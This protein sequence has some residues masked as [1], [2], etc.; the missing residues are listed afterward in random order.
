MTDLS[1]REYQSF[2]TIS[3]APISR[4]IK[5]G[6]CEVVS[7][8]AKKSNPEGQPLIS[9][10]FSKLTIRSVAEESEAFL[11]SPE[12]RVCQ[13]FRSFGPVWSADVTDA[14]KGTHLEAGSSETNFLTM[15][16]ICAPSSRCTSS[17]C[18]IL[19]GL[20]AMMLTSITR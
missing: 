5:A 10:S 6:C 16:S 14:I 17:I 4:V 13:T 19:T 7:A 11:C 8:L 9:L 15:S 18:L 1:S 20:P 3:A 12:V 2:P